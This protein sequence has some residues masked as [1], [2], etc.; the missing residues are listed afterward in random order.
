VAEGASIVLEGAMAAVDVSGCRGRRAGQWNCG[1]DSRSRSSAEG[2]RGVEGRA[3][4][5]DLRRQKE[6][7]SAQVQRRTLVES[8]CRHLARRFAIRDRI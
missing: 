2:E 7:K 5:S 1:A 4:R 6:R 3:T 8:R